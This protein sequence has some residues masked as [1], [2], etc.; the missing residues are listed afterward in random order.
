MMNN[1][2]SPDFY[3]MPQRTSSWA[4][5]NGFAHWALAILWLIVALI[6]FQVVA[7]LVLVGLL[8]F[9][10]ELTAAEDVAEVLMSRVDLLFIGNSIGQVLFIGLATFVIVQLHAGSDKKWSFLRLQWK[11]KTPL[12]LGL[13]FF[14]V[15]AVQPIVL[16]LGYVNSL[17]P[18]PDV[19]S[20]MQISQYQMIEEFLKTDGIL[21]FGLFHIALIPAFCEEVLFR[22][23][24]LRAFEK[25]WG[26]IA[27][28]IVSGIVFGMFHIQLG[29]LMP[30]A[31]LG[32]VLAVMTWLS[33]S[34]WPAVLAHFIN[35]GAA[36]VLGVSYP[37]LVFR[38]VTPEVLPPV[39]L[40]LGSIFL[41]ILLVYAMIRQ[42]SVNK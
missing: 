30:L 28:I 23:Y 29:N 17:L 3:S 13:G 40:L 19:F 22:G 18:I 2:N 37:E 31:F 42:S 27:A 11:E 6:L 5:R 8:F 41:T 35:N 38:D 25:S 15:L 14:L 1:E 9:S 12:F 34:I 16:Y 26:I 24:V 36:V 33:G 32:M 21:L 20:D 7:G 39:W 10:G 4:E